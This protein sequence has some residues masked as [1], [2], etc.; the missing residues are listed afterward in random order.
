MT[1]TQYWLRQNAS[2][3][4]LSQATWAG[5]VASQPSDSDACCSPSSIQGYLMVQDGCS[6]ISFH[7][8]LLASRKSKKGAEGNPTSLKDTS[9][10]LQSYYFS[11]SVQVAIENYHRASLVAQWLRICLLMQG[12][13]VRALVWEDPT[14]HGAA[15]PVSHNC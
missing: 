1:G 10:K 3:I 13:R 8:H 7:G 6:S 2:L 4:F 14:C 11:S 15:G 12:T 5:M 9:W